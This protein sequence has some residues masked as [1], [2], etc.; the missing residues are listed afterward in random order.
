MLTQQQPM[1][2]LWTSLLGNFRVNQDPIDSFLKL[3]QAAPELFDRKQ[4]VSQLSPEIWTKKFDAELHL[5]AQKIELEKIRHNWNM[6]AME[7]QM[8]DSNAK[9]WMQM[10]GST[11]EKLIGPLINTAG[12]IV[13]N[14]MMAKQEAQGRLNCS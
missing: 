4:E 9:E 8:G 6:E 10:I 2:E 5:M 7:K 3:K 12:A 11:G 14:K 13:A 1:K